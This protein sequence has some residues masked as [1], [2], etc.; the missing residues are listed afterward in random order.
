MVSGEWVNDRDRFGD[1]GAHILEVVFIVCCLAA[2]VGYIRQG[3]A[4]TAT[5]SIG[6]DGGGEIKI[7]ANLGGAVVAHPCATSA[8]SYLERLTRLACVEQGYQRKEEL[9]H[10]VQNGLRCLGSAR[11][12]HRRGRGDRWAAGPSAL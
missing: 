12:L 2:C 6:T 7:R 9:Q 1:V 5:L 4:D 3:S 8:R 10:S 11:R